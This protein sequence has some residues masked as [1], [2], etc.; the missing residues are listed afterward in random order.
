MLA[1]PHK[2]GGADPKANT[3][4]KNGE[5]GEGRN[6]TGR[7]GEDRH[8]SWRG[9]NELRGQGC[10]EQLGRDEGQ[11]NWVRMERGAE[12]GRGELG[13]GRAGPGTRAGRGICN[14]LIYYLFSG[15]VRK[16]DNYY[17]CHT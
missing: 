3:W 7:E 4:W 16:I 9:G 15:N 12:E 13:T 17:I 14:T 10:T 8:G 6:T 11:E 5:P 2:A 1:V